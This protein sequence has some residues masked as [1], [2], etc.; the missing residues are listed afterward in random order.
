MTRG[1][2]TGRV[3][4]GHLLSDHG[5]PTPPKAEPLAGGG[6]E[7][8][9]G[10]AE[11]P[12]ILAPRE[13][14][15]H[16]GPGRGLAPPLPTPPARGRAATPAPAR[17]PLCSRRATTPRTP[18]PHARD[19]PTPAFGWAGRP[20][21]DSRVA[22]VDPGGDLVAGLARQA[23]AAAAVRQQ[24]VEILHR[25][26]ERARHGGGRALHAGAAACEGRAAGSAGR[27][28]PSRDPPRPAPEAGPPGA[29]KG[30]ARTVGA[31]SSPQEGAPPGAA[32]TL[33]GPR[34]CPPRRR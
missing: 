22:H 23:V 2:E 16:A 27:G 19:A 7:P 5:S 12:G 13:G 3:T 32:R 4:E 17:P 33:R 8:D 28:L 9:A 11:R 6:F 18:P 14:E 25:E 24:V 20:S 10:P 21:G 15:D 31:L 26:L 29:G 34:A 30:G 1:L